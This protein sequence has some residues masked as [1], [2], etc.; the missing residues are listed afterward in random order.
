M[1]LPRHLPGVKLLKISIRIAGD[2]TEI[3]TVVH[4]NTS[5][6]LYRYVIRFR[7]LCHCRRKRQAFG[8]YLGISRQEKAQGFPTMQLPYR[9][10]GA[11][12]FPELK[13]ASSLFKQ[14]RTVVS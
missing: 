9:L 3:R 5:P 7:L 14:V 4:P 12:T 6:E 13:L 1:V 10:K 2:P 11:G 8:A